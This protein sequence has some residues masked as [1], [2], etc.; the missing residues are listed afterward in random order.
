MFL[1]HGK[2]DGLADFAA[3][4]IAQGIFQKRLAEQLVGGIGK[5]P[6]LKLA[7][8]VSFLLVVAF[9]ILELDDKTLLGQQL[10]GNFRPGIHDRG[11]DEEAVLHPIQQ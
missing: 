2:N 3:D 10:G 7:L 4:G 1:A 6:F 9:V 8:L 5:E 11:I